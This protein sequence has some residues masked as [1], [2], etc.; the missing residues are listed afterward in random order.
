MNK[1]TS[2]FVIL[3][4]ALPTVTAA[5]DDDVLFDVIKLQVQVEAQ[6]PNDHMQVILAAEKEG[7]D[8]RAISH[9]INQT[10]RWALDIIKQYPEIDSRSGNYQTMPIYNKQ[11]I[12]A[13]RSVQEIVLES[14]SI[15]KLSELTGTLQ[16]R[17]Q[18]R[19]MGFSPSKEQADQ[20]EARLV[21]EGMQA[22]R[23]RAEQLRKHMN[24][25]QYR[26]IEIHINTGRQHPPIRHETSAVRSLSMDAT[27][28]AVEAGT[29]ELTVTVSGSVQYF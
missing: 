17:L 21:D 28:P 15:S 3:L 6:V 29:S 24:G 9:T 12:S 23:T 14:E 26:I 2:L 16:Q 1:F 22:F 19:N 4:L 7:T 8:P 13:W 5:H 10:M 20:F 18:V 11:T 25:R 27:P